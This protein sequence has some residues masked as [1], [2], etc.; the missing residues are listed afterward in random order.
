MG[1]QHGGMEKDSEHSIVSAT[2]RFT[3]ELKDQASRQT[4]K[5]ASK[6]A[7]NHVENVIPTTLRGNSDLR[8]II[9][10]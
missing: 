7:S 10:P 8:Q 4:G 9:F 3:W 1:I 2:Y 5:Q 6:Q